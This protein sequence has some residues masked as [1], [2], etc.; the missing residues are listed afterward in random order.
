MLELR[1]YE[2]AH[3]ITATDFLH[4][5]LLIVFFKNVTLDHVLDLRG[6]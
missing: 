1:L 6:V 3:L 5:D 4:I 2:R